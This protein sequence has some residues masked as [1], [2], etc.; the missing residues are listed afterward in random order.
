[1]AVTFEAV[2]KN[3][4]KAQVGVHSFVSLSLSLWPSSL[5]PERKKRDRGRGKGGRRISMASPSSEFQL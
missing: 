2:R 3:D 5:S 1:M 4:S